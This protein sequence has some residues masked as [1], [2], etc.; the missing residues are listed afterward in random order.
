V[1]E[2]TFF[3]PSKSF[4]TLSVTGGEC[5]LDCTHCRKL[6][7]QNMIPTSTPESL[8]ET[9]LSLWQ[10][11]VEGVLVSG[12]CDSEG[13]VPLFFDIL[14]EIRKT[15]GLILNVHSGFVDEKNLSGLKIANPHYV[16]FD[17]P[18]THA[19]RNVYGINRRSEDYIHSLRLLKESGLVA[20]PHVCLGMNN[21]SMEEREILKRISRISDKVVLTVVF[22][23]RGTD[24]ESTRLNSEEIIDIFRFAR[25]LFKTINLG[26][27]R[28]RMRKIEEE[29]LILNGIVQPTQWARRKAQGLDLQI[30]EKKTCCVVD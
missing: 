21:D 11:N 19:L 5:A 3:Y 10:K 18:T 7:L 27:M 29:A 28:P 14:G 24:F 13:R 12:G 2:I 4:P 23:A 1:R 9:C 17:I 16:S 15:T 6:F 30:R 26:C 8:S 22:S 25:P 20:V